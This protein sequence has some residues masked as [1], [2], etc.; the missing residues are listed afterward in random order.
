MPQIKRYKGR[1]YGKVQGVYFRA[2]AR[3]EA[4]RL[5]LTGWIRNVEDGSVEFEVQGPEEAVKQFLEWSK[6]GPPAA[7]VDNLKIEEIP[8][9]EGE[10]EF[11]IKY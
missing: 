2:S 11:I 9:V 6:E 5:G 8:I 4:H 3:E 1:V 7:R 10:S